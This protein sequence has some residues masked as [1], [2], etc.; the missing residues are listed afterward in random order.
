MT[1]SENNGCMFYEVCEHLMWKLT[2]SGS[3]EVDYDVEPEFMDES[4]STGIS[5]Q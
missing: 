2:D 1:Y 5:M 4:D 3:A